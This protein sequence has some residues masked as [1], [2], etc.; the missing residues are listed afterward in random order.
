MSN[1]QKN[2]IKL[3]GLL[4]A[5]LLP[6]SWSGAQ[7]LKTKNSGRA[8]A[9]ELKFRQTGV[10]VFDLV[11]KR[12]GELIKVKIIPQ[13]D[14]GAEAE[15]A[16]DALKV[17]LP[18]PRKL[19]LS[20]IK[21]LQ[22][23]PLIQLSATFKPF[24]VDL[25]ARVVT[26]PTS[27]GQVP[28]VKP[29]ASLP[30][31]NLN[32]ADVEPTKLN[33]MKSDEFKMLQALIFL[34]HKKK[35]DLAMALFVELMDSAEFKDQA[36]YHYAETALG[37]KLWSEFRNRMLTVA[38]S[39]KNL[40]LKERAIKS[41]VQNIEHLE[42]SDIGLI[43]PFAEAMQID[44]STNPRYS[45]KKAKYFSE[46]GDLGAFEQ[47]LLEI[48]MKSPQY[49]ESVLL[50]ALFN[51]RQGQVEASISDLEMIWPDIED[52][53]KDQVRNLSALT[54]ARLHFQKGDYKNAYK[55][56]L[57]VDRSSGQWLQSMVEQAWTQ[58]LAGDYEGA[59]GNMFSL[60]TD[61]FKKAY[62][63]DT[64]VVR[65]VGYLNLCQYGDS[66]NVL[67][68]LKKKYEGV[69]AKLM[70]F[71]SKNKEP[72]AY[73]ELVKTWMKNTELGEVNGV[74]RAFIVELARHP[75]Y[76]SIQKQINNYED[77]NSK[78]NQVTI[79][80][81]RKERVARLEMIKAK[82]ALA[83]AKREKSSNLAALESD[84]MAMGI[85]HLIYSRARDGIKKMRESAV[86]RIEKEESGLKLK[87]GQNL[88]SRFTTFS[89]T[90]DNLIDQKEV[91]SYEIFSG[92]GDHIRFQ[93]AGGDVNPKDDRAP[94]ALKPEE[95]NSYKWK[96]KGEVWEDEIGHYR[97]SLKNVC[98]QEDGI[99]KASDVGP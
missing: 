75:N 34:E 87:A 39:S 55:Y 7:A 24:P 59:A 52:K 21:T 89:G 9:P 11:E 41:L 17:S 42:I 84:Y 46:K 96:H 64:Y 40:D 27:V 66:V 44:T 29:L 13:L 47:A 68:E 83:A 45:L 98:P 30:T 77:E 48:P 93:M 57:V 15:L 70:S 69:H 91:L 65:T 16:A 97:S 60:H 8:P 76:M 10:P 54:L 49:H 81:I 78:F 74:S 22:S 37:L 36:T 14:I 26:N 51:Y 72:L 73:Y 12:G 25:Q 6:C 99:A 19:N 71:Q 2:A 62:A 61:F 90:L 3:V 23:P 43:E 56:Y 20:P 94:A 95:D 18:A 92:A 33:E 82:N 1:Q 79:D 67:N 63:P 31:M 80:L 86:A 53:K 85:E 28:S 35:Y 38:Q 58:V 32:P 88:Q 4:F 5:F 50:R